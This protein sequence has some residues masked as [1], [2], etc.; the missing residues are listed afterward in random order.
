MIIKKEN[1]LQ[2]IYYEDE[3][4]SCNSFP[5]KRKKLIEQSKILTKNDR[6]NVVKYIDKFLAITKPLTKPCYPNI[7]YQIINK[8][9]TITYLNCEDNWFDFLKLKHE[10]FDN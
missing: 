5:F 3:V 10:L 2:T 6:V 4:V 7:Y 1:D 8:D 9:T